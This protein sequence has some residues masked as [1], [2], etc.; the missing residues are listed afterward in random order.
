MIKERERRR[1][2]RGRERRGRGKWYR[3]KERE[4]PL[5]QVH[6]HITTKLDVQGHSTFHVYH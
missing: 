6:V 1:E 5:N 2:R 4:G 3:V